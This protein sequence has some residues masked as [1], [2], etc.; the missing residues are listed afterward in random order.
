MLQF[1]R[2]RACCLVTALVLAAGT[3]TTAFDT[4]LHAGTAHDVACVP[5]VDVA[6]DASSHRV[7]PPGD[8]ANPDHHCVGCHLARTPRLGPQTTSTGAHVEEASALRPMAAIGSARA[9]ALDNLPPRSPPS[10]S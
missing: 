6:H 9:A 2:V 3:T 10:V 4:L 1:F 5:D 8:A 7:R